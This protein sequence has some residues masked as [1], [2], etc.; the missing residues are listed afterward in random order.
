MG[1]KITT[2]HAAKLARKPVRKAVRFQVLDDGYNQLHYI[3]G[4]LEMCETMVDGFSFDPSD[5]DLDESCAD[6]L[7][8]FIDLVGGS[9]HGKQYVRRKALWPFG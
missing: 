3:R 4:L 9:Q 5:P 6:L 7:S 2:K 1:K 8:R